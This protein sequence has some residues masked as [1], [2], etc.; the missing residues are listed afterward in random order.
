MEQQARH[1]ASRAVHRFDLEMD[2][3]LGECLAQIEAKTK[4]V[5]SKKELMERHLEGLRHAAALGYSAADLSEH[6]MREL[7][8]QISPSSLREALRPPRMAKKAAA[9][10]RQRKPRQIS[11]STPVVEVVAQQP[12]VGRVTDSASPALPLF[13]RPHQTVFDPENPFDDDS[14][15][16]A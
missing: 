9:P 16:E 13:Q 14:E 15:G 6:L 7:G 5:F 10:Q 11:A 4:S 2:R 1:T 12:V 8:L 3:R